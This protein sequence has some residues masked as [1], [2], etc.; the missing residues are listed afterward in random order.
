VPGGG[1]ADD[2]DPRRVDHTLRV[3]LQIRTLEAQLESLPK[4]SQSIGVGRTPDAAPGEELS[5]S[6]WMEAPRFE[7]VEEPLATVSPRDR[8]SP[9]RSHAPPM[10]NEKWRG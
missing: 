5:V 2:S 9:R 10:V 1:G 3:D 7:D 6:D 4:P 8:I